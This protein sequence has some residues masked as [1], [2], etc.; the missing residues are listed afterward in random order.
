MFY[1]DYIK[2]LW[3]LFHVKKDRGNL[4]AGLCPILP[5][6]YMCSQHLRNH[7]C[8]GSKR[9]MNAYCSPFL[10]VFVCTKGFST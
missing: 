7:E 10:I 4:T 3:K 8:N 5:E 2:V 1:L 9:W 6:L